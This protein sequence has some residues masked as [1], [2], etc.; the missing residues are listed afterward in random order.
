MSS[1][2]LAWLTL[3]GAGLLEIVWAISMKYSE[4]FTRILPSVLTVAFISISVYLLSLAIKE[5]PIGV[6]YAV[7]AGIGAAGV[8]IFGII[9]FNEPSSFSHTACLAMIITGV[10]GLNL[11]SH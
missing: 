3:I 4:G 5:I 9:I 11:L 6:A 8:S 10:I 7:W 1:T 2:F